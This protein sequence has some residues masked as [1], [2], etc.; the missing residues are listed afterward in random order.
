MRAKDTN[1]LGTLNDELTIICPLTIGK[2]AVSGSFYTIH[3]YQ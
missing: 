1:N 3:S 2:S